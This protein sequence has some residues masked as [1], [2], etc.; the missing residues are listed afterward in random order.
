MIHCLGTGL[1]GAWVA[2]RL[3]SAGHE[4]H[5]YDIHPH[6]VMGIDGIT[7]HPCDVIEDIV[8]M[9]QNGPVDMVVNMSLI[10]I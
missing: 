10:H 9:N 1:V 3:A 7:V 5:A 8:L 4:V 2:K 6:R